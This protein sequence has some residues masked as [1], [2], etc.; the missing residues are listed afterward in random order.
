MVNKEI[1]HGKLRGLPRETTEYGKALDRR[2]GVDMSIS[3]K[4]QMQSW[5]AQEAAVI[6]P[7]CSLGL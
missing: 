1:R 2:H 6:L 4:V 3:E 7:T 5:H